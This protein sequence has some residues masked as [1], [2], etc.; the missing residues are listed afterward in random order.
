MKFQDYIVRDPNI[1]NGVPVIKGTQVALN[2]V[3]EHLS[4]GDTL[5]NIVSSY[6]GLTPEAVRAVIAY[7]ASLAKMDLDRSTPDKGEFFSIDVV[8]IYIR[9]GL[10]PQA[11]NII[12]YM[13]RKDPKNPKLKKKLEQLKKLMK[14]KG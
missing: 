10:Y 3:L 14:R 11:T 8:N 7:A 1:L 13:L 4:L 12:R 6:P 5:E 2:V 9:Q